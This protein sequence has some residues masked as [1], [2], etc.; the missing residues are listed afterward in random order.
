M[1]Y[2][3]RGWKWMLCFIIPWFVGVYEIVTWLL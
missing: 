2:T 1:T 3:F